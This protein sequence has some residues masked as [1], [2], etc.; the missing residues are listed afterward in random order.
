[1]WRL[2]INLS[3]LLAV[4][5]TTGLPA[6]SAQEPA[7]PLVLPPPGSSPLA[8]SHQQDSA[9]QA[10]SPI[11]ELLIETQPDPE[12]NLIE[13]SDQPEPV[14]Y[15]PSYWFGPAPW[16]IGV[17]FGLNG[18]EGVNQALSMRSG[19]HLKRET[20]FWKFD[21][22]LVYNRNSANGIENPE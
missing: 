21:S 9:E 11:A 6:A 3:L 1:M 7:A 22:S 18:S 12:S 19:G 2:D 5:L 15:Q 17:E 20:E 16:D 4:L 13:L 8:N 14:W 10:E